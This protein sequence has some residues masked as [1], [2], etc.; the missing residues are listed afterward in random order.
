LAEQLLAFATGWEGLGFLGLCLLAL[1]FLAGTVSFMPRFTFYSIAGAVFGLAAIPAAIA[2][3]VVGATL[4]FLLAHYALRDTF[5]RQVEKRPRWRKLLDAVNTE[6]WRLVVLTRFTSP[7]PGGAINYV[8]GL[9]AIGLVPYVV[10]TALGLLPPVAAFTGLGMV[11]RVALSGAEP[12]RTETA[13]TAASL[14][15]I[16]IT[17][18][19]IVR[20]MRATST[21]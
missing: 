20:R 6:G 3:S 1:V 14:I 4:A 8:F 9:T 16:A 19:L 11:G 10:A 15:V 2:G 7:L 12:S 17:V 5:E 13:I 21:K 18:M